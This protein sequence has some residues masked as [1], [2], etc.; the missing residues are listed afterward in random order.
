M[1][2]ASRSQYGHQPPQKVIRSISWVN[3]LLAFC[4]YSEMDGDESVVVQPV[5]K[6]TKVAPQFG[7]LAVTTSSTALQTLTDSMIYLY[8]YPF[9]CTGII[10]TF[11]IIL[12]SKY[13]QNCW[14]WL[15]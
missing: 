13:A 12:Q 10:T 11:E 5:K 4:T 14:D 2:S 1:Q 8:E 15:L 9:E 7:Q 3:S 6:P